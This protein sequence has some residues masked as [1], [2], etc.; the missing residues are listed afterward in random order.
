M[1]EEQATFERSDI[2]GDRT[3]IIRGELDMANAD[4]LQRQLSEVMS[5]AHSPAF[6]DLSAVELID[7]PSIAKLIDAH[8]Q[9]PVHG[10]ELILLSPSRPCRRVLD[11]LGLA[12]HFTI[13][14]C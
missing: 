9:A 13:K 12:D 11:V 14:E 3:L 7:C 5:E 6:I 4:T 10:T 2:N 1:S 8:R